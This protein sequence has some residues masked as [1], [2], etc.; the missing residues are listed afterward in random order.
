MYCKNCNA[1]IDPAFKYCMEC[2]APVR[3]DL[4]H[5]SDAWNDSNVLNDDMDDISDDES[6]YYTEDYDE[7]I[8]IFSRGRYQTQSE[9]RFPFKIIATA[10]CVLILVLILLIIIGSC[11]NSSETESHENE[12]YASESVHIPDSTKP[13]NIE[14]TL[15]EGAGS[16]QPPTEVSNYVTRS[17]EVA[18]LEYDKYIEAERIRAFMG[19]ANSN[20]ITID[21]L[22]RQPEYYIGKEVYFGGTVLQTMYDT[23][24][25]SAVDL[26]VKVNGAKSANN[27]IYVTYKLKDGNMRILEDDYVDLY[28]TFD[29]MI[30]YEAVLGNNVT[31]PRINGEHIYCHADISEPVTTPVMNDALSRISKNFKSSTGEIFSFSNLKNAEDNIFSDAT[32]YGDCI[33]L[34][35]SPYEGWDT[36][37]SPPFYRVA[38]FE[39]GT[40]VIFEPF[41]TAE[42]GIYAI[43]EGTYSEYTP[44][45]FEGTASP[46]NT[47]AQSNNATQPISAPKTISLNK[48]AYVIASSGGLNI[49]SGPDINYDEVGRLEPL[50]I[51]TIIEIQQGRNHEWGRIDRGW[52]CM[53][54]VIIG[55]PPVY[56]DTYEVGYIFGT[57]EGVNLRSGPGINYDSLGKIPLGKQVIVTKVCD[58]DSFTWGFIGNGWICTDYIKWGEPGPGT[59]Y[60]DESMLNPSSPWFVGYDYYGNPLY[61]GY[62]VRVGTQEGSTEYALGIVTLDIE[63]G[64]PRVDFTDVCDDGGQTGNNVFFVNGLAEKIREHGTYSYRVKTENLLWHTVYD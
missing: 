33:V 10:S 59:D 13:D 42:A 64:L 60:Y 20:N 37:T 40:L 50:E 55:T 14:A 18:L 32:N 16:N 7:Q 31:I 47:T 9:S 54:Y 43:D 5:G 45:S 49:R 1:E 19:K 51:I 26:R 53:D 63:N 36:N 2:G 39:D 4:D 11:D 21:M 15:S 29:G 38:A 58:N 52:V 41:K 25:S 48:I 44:I 61:E 34:Y 46:Q 3:H 62:S 22:N 6:S 56:V 35:Y 30:T 17:R 12:I 24:D 27:V 57:A 28:G 23:N 8:P